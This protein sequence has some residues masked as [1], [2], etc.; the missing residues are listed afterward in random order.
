GEDM[1]K[2]IE[3]V[4]DMR[5][6]LVNMNAA[7]RDDEMVNIFLQSVVDSHRNV[8]RMFNRNN[9]GGAAPN[10]VT[11][12]NVLLGEAEADKACAVVVTYIEEV[13]NAIKVISQCPAP[14]NP[15]NKFKKRRKR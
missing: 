8:V 2:Y 5:R 10:L 4:E 1:E 12:V 15:K 6:Q 14:Q 11:I 3:R 9:A 13:E 7:I